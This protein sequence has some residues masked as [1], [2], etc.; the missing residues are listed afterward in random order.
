MAQLF[1]FRAPGPWRR[2]HLSNCP[3]LFKE[4][5]TFLT[6]FLREK[7]QRN[8]SS[9]PLEPSALAPPQQIVHNP[10]IN[11]SVQT[12]HFPTS[13]RHP[14][15]SYPSNDCI[16]LHTPCTYCPT[17]KT[18]RRIANL[19]FEK[20]RRN[21]KKNDQKQQKK[22][23]ALE[24]HGKDEI[25]QY[26]HRT[27]RKDRKGTPLKAKHATDNP[28]PVQYS[29]AGTMLQRTGQSGSCKIP[30]CIYRTNLIG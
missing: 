12:N 29:A 13:P 11:H 5:T 6:T 25:Q 27:R 23:H 3:Y 10:P 17:P 1:F 15:P 26:T 4:I 28:N 18:C 24:V 2:R 8:T 14:T 19:F 21:K 20:R 30:V 9:L 16:P 7:T 22:T